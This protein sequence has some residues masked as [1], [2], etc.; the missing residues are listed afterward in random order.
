MKM[1]LNLAPVILACFVSLAAAHSA[2]A[3]TITRVIEM[4]FGAPSDPIAVADL[5]VS[6]DSDADTDRQFI[7]ADARL[8]ILALTIDFDTNG[9]GTRTR[10][11]SDTSALASVRFR[12]DDGLLQVLRLTNGSGAGTWTLDLRVSN[13]NDGTSS[14]LTGQINSGGSDGLCGGTSFTYWFQA[15]SG[16]TY[17]AAS[18]GVRVSEPFQA[19]AVPLPAGVWLLLTGLGAVAL[20]RR[21]PAGHL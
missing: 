7:D 19:S 9:D 8:S 15:N 21:R 12:T 13:L 2:A 6:M 20:M 18:G 1:Y 10:I 3:S 17:C 14:I 11:V 16:Q 5:T 4:D